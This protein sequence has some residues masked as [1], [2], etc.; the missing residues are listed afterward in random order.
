MGKGLCCGFLDGKEL[1]GIGVIFKIGISF[2]DQRVAANPANAP[3]SHVEAF[4]KR[5]K[6][7]SDIISTRDLENGERRIVIEGERG[8]SSVLDDN[9]IVGFGPG[10]CIGVKFWGG[11][12]SSG[13]IRVVEDEYFCLF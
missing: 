13:V 9:D 1:A 5:M 6:L 8:I 11:R 10:D 3:A 7:D 4:G 2:D 12:G